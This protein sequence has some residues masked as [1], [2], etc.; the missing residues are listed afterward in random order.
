[1]AL[2]A[3]RSDRMVDAG[4]AFYVDD[5]R[6]KWR[7]NTWGALKTVGQQYRKTFVQILKNYPRNSMRRPGEYGYV[8][9][10]QGKARAWLRYAEIGCVVAIVFVGQSMRHRP[11]T[12]PQ[13]L[14]RG[15]V[16][17]AAFVGL[18][19]IWA[20]RF[21]ISRQSAGSISRTKLGYYALGAVCIIG[22]GV[23]GSQTVREARDSVGSC[24]LLVGGEHAYVVV[25]SMHLELVRSRMS[26]WL[27][28][29]GRP[30]FPRVQNPQIHRYIIETDGVSV[31][32][33]EL[34]AG[35]GEEQLMP[36]GGD[37]YLVDMD[38]GGRAWKWQKGEGVDVTPA[39]W[40]KLCPTPAESIEEQCRAQGWQYTLL[41]EIDSAK[42]SK[43]LSLGGR[44][45]HVDLALEEV[46]NG[47]GV[48]PT[49]VLRVN[50]QVPGAPAFKRVFPESRAVTR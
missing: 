8:P 10:H 4:Y 17:L 43:T 1:M 39:E 30:Q 32:S 40:K 46:E 9:S 45:V 23:Y 6:D 15:A 34:P 22:L 14:F 18:L 47:P 29:L 48:W 33:A 37:L 19:S 28:R 24:E 42:L 49:E 21:W 20:T 5:E 38:E 31:I 27:E 50:L 16:L 7:L 11:V 3:Q 35:I 36:V 25:G 2:F 44:E 41:Q 26:E 13:L 12:L